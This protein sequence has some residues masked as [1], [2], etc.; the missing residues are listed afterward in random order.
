[1]CN[2]KEVFFYYYYYYLLHRL[3]GW[4]VCEARGRRE[5][6]FLSGRSSGRKKFVCSLICNIQEVK[7]AAFCF[8]VTPPLQ[9]H[10][11]IWITFQRFTH[12]GVT[13]RPTGAAGAAG[14]GQTTLR[15]HAAQAPGRRLGPSW[16]QQLCRW[17]SFRLELL[18]SPSVSATLAEGTILHP[19]SSPNGPDSTCQCWILPPVSGGRIK[20]DPARTSQFL[21]PNEHRWI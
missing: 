19:G 12:A 8:R 21:Q 15:H 5:E 9:R 4:R 20:L 3:I 16:N 18:S 1:M 2:S 13:P 6:W 17:F 14:C 7:R 11:P 10:H